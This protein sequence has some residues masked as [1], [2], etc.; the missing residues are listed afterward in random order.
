MRNTVYIH[1][2]SDHFDKKRFRKVRNCILGDIGE[3]PRAGTGLW[4]SP[5]DSETTWYDWCEEEDFHIDN[6]SSSFKFKLLPTARVLYIRNWDELGEAKAIYQNYGWFAYIYQFD[7]GAMEENMKAKF[8]PDFERIAND[9][10]AM[11]VRMWW[12]DGINSGSYYQLYG[13]DV[14]SLLVLN[15][16]VVEELDYDAVCN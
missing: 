6:L 4:A 2:G 10:D 7:S 5:V 14:D 11:Y 12:G 13:W 8:A 15:P 3:K 9:Y 16:Y 1:Y